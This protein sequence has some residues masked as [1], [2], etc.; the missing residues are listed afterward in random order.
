MDKIQN[1]LYSTHDKHNCYGKQVNKT[2]A[3]VVY[4][5]SDFTTNKAYAEEKRLEGFTIQ[6]IKG[7]R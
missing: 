7:E 5:I 4:Q 3:I 6:V 1:K 2:N